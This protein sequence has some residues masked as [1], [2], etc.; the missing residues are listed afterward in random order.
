[1]ALDDGRDGYGEMS[2]EAN[3]VVEQDAGVEMNFV[4]DEADGTPEEQKRWWEWHLGH[5]A[6]KQK[7]A[8]ETAMFDVSTLE[9][10]LSFQHLNLFQH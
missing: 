1:M 3:G 8:C 2:G 7:E 4:L 10:V 5:C 6:L 9:K